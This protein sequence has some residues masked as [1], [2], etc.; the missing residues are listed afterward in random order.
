VNNVVLVHG[1]N[2]DGTTWR[3]VYDGLT[4]D[5]YKV[6]VVQLPMTSVE[7]D[8]AAVQRIIDSQDGPLILAGHSYGGLVISEVGDAPNVRG[9]VYVAAF[10][11]DEGES[12]GGGGA[13]T[14][15]ATLGSTASAASVEACS[16]SAAGPLTWDR[17]S[18]LQASSVSAAATAS[19][20][21]AL[22]PDAR[23]PG[24]KSPS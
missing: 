2:T 11:P 21:A 13:S 23:F 9:L 24:S 10:A 8:M 14:R 19:A 5:A 6:S 1:A 18:G 20:S 3:E 16:T 7:D 12:A 22:P 17:I 4:A 15:V